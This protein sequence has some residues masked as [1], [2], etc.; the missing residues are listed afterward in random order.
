[1]QWLKALGAAM[2][3]LALVTTPSLAKGPNALVA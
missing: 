1:M 3:A 2:A